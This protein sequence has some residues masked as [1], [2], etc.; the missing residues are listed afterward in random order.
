MIPDRII[1]QGTL[2]TDGGRAAVEVR[3][4]WYRALPG[5][6]IA[7]AT[8]TIDG[9]A[10]P[11]E[12]LRWHMN[13]REFT[14]DEL[15]TTTDEWWFPTDSVVLSGDLPIE[16]DAEHEVT[17]GL[18]LYIPYII[19]SDTETLHIDESNTKTMKAVAA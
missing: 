2:T 15:R 14:F 5:S 11:A 8:L 10:A 7:G 4:P 12:S 3:L 9:A 13:D 18:T 17:V 19:I 1:E 6:C 16:A